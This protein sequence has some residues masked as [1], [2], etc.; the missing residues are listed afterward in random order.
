MYSDSTTAI[1]EINAQIKFE[2]TPNII[3]EYAFIYFDPAS[4]NNIKGELYSTQG[5]LLQTFD[6]MQPSISY[7]LDFT[8]YPSGNYFLH[9]SS[10]NVSRVEKIV[11]VK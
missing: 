2:I 6:F 3:N 1:H 10:K 4:E 9:L 7:T 11:V 5:R 8:K